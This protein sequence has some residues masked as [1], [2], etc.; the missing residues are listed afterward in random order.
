MTPEEARQQAN[1][2]AKKAEELAK[3][4]AKESLNKLDRAQTAMDKLL[5]QE[6]EKAGMPNADPQLAQMSDAE[7]QQAMDQAKQESAEAQKKIESLQSQL[8]AL[9][10][11]LQN[12]KL[13]EAERKALEEQKKALQKEMKAAQEAK[14]AADQKMQALKL[15]EEAR[16]VFEKMMQHP[17]YK[18]LQELA[19][20]M[21]ENAQQA[22]QQGRP[23]LSKEEMEKLRQQLEELAKQL[24]DDK[25]MEEFLQAM[26][27]AM[28]E[29]GGSCRLGAVCMGLGSIVPIPGAGGPGPDDDRMLF[30]SGRVNKLDKGVA[31]AGKTNATQVVGQR[32]E[33]PGEETYIEIKAPTTVGNRSSVPYVKVLPSYRKKAESALDRQQ[34]PKEHEKRVREYFESLGK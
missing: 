29:G 28:K 9:N 17:L 2:I 15:S 4:S 24:A 30:D 20:K 23:P 31:G 5:K 3:Q 18:Q 12:P 6:L 26:L 21:R 1:E 11:K 10:R 32:R 22:A 13:S 34:I 19:Q 25:K 33:G 7:R 14:K 27:D 8:D 16:K